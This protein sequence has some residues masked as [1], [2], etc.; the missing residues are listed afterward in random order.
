MI[1]RSSFLLVSWP[2]SLK[3]FFHSFLRSLRYLIILVSW[4]FIF[5]VVILI[6]LSDFLF[7]PNMFFIFSLS[8]KSFLFFVVFFWFMLFFYLFNFLFS[9]LFN[10]FDLLFDLLLLGLIAFISLDDIL[11]FLDLF[12]LFSN[13]FLDLFNNYIRKTFTLWCFFLDLFCN[14]SY[15]VNN[16][17]CTLSSRIIDKTKGKDS[18]QQLHLR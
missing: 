15:S 14:L 18:S 12:F 2:L 7:S 11:N 16:V 10:L 8:F 4:I 13:L 6:F 1:F 5:L 9:L 3:I 17:C